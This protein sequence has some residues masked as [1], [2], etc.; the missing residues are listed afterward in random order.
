M[1]KGECLR[2]LHRYKLNYTHA[3]SIDVGCEVGFSGQAVVALSTVSVSA[4]S[5][6][7]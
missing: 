3:S 2:T 6:L 4:I 5:P 1:S 7:D